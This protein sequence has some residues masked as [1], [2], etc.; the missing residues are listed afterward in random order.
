MNKPNKI[1]QI[2]SIILIGLLFDPSLHAASDNDDLDTAKALKTSLLFKCDNAQIIGINTY[3]K[4]SPWFMEFSVDNNNKMHL[5]A[6]HKA[7]FRHNGTRLTWIEPKSENQIQIDPLNDQEITYIKK[8]F[9]TEETIK[10]T[11]TVLTR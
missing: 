3:I 8:L 9:N 7:R 6:H 11:C 5:I 4:F 10:T 1:L 2:T